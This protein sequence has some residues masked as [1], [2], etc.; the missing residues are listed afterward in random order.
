MRNGIGKERV[1]C[2]VYM[3]YGGVCD[4]EN[5]YKEDGNGGNA[6]HLTHFPLDCG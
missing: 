5:I 1:K 4:N 3:Q 6:S 2:V